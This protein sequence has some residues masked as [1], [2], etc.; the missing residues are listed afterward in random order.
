[1]GTGVGGF[2]IDEA[3]RIMVNEIVK[4]IDE[5]TSLRRII[6]VGF[7]EDMT[8]AFGRALKRRLL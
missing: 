8:Q 3:A 2:D 5:G 1:M 7:S 6:L 4:H